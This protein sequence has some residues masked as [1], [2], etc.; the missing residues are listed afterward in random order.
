MA[1]TCVKDSLLCRQ[2]LTSEDARQSRAQFPRPDDPARNHATGQM[3][4]T[5]RRV[6]DV[7]SPADAFEAALTEALA[8]ESTGEGPGAER[9]GHNMET[10]GAATT[11]TPPNTPDVTSKGPANPTLSPRPVD[12]QGGR[13]EAAA[14]PEEATQAAPKEARQAAP[15]QAEGAAEQPEISTQRSMAPDKAARQQATMPAAPSAVVAQE[16]N[17]SND[18]DTG[19][20]GGVPAEPA[21]VEAV[22]EE[23]VGN[24]RV[25][26]RGADVV[27]QSMESSLGGTLYVSEALAALEEQEGQSAAATQVLCAHT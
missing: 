3:R 8:K 16:Q 1:C 4:E 5:G 23:E 12:S 9:G 11:R 24:A 25:S 22:R 15:E 2:V 6:I 21:K 13:A 26:Q 10:D 19:K 20:A 27:Q 17:S 7:T 14:G 18:Q